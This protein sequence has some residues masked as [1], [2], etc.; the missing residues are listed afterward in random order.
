MSKKFFAAAA[1]ALMVLSAGVPAFAQTVGGA[2]RDN[3]GG[4]VRQ[5]VEFF[6][7]GMYSRA[8]ALFDGV[9]DKDAFSEG[10]STLCSVYLKEPGYEKRIGE[11][12]SRYPFSGL[13]PSVR[14][15]YGL[16]LFDEED[17]EGA[18]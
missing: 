18:L 15:R 5:G 13:L 1:A 9:S 10:M 8:R 12:A 2:V 17:F 14:F 6:E 11:Y 3:A 16:N 4:Q 7:K